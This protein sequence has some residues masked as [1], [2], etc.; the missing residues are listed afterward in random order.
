L[1]CSIGAFSSSPV[2]AQKIKEKP[3]RPSVIRVVV[4]PPVRDGFLD[5]SSGNIDSANDIRKRLT[6]S[7]EL[8]AVHSDEPHDVTLLVVA[9]GAG[10]EEYGRIVKTAT[11]FNNTIAW[12]EP[13][14]QTDYWLSAII[15]T[16][17][18]RKA[19]VG[20]ATSKGTTTPWGACAD[21]VIDELGV[22]VANNVERLL[23]RRP[24]R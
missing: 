20:R 13:I 12:T 6:R 19:I 21:R 7:Q 1:A 15:E 17:V 4:T 11:L 3:Q 8:V 9:R 10:F 16:D 18:Y 24:A 5:A 14:G 22:W 23:A 2:V